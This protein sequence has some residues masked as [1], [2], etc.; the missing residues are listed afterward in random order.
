LCP[1]PTKITLIFV[2]LEADENNFC[3]FMGLPTKILTGPRKYSL[4]SS[5]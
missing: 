3:I 1:R 2:G 5:A 4:F